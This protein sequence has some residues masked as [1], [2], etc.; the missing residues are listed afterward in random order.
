MVVKRG[1]MTPS[2]WLKVIVTLVVGL[3]PGIIIGVSMLSEHRQHLKTLD[4]QFDQ[5]QERIVVLERQSFNRWP[6]KAN[7]EED[8]NGPTRQ[9]TD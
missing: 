5:L 7:I 6:S 3:A 1:N 4:R 2:D 9:S 8:L